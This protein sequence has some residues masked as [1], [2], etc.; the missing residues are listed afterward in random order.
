MVYSFFSNWFFSHEKVAAQIEKNFQ[1]IDVN[2]DNFNKFS[3]I[4]QLQ[5]EMSLVESFHLHEKIRSMNTKRIVP[6][7]GTSKITNG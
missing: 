5:N 6:L 1:K 2:I 7:K 4:E 3:V